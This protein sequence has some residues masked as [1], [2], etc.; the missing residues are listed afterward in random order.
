MQDLIH[1]KGPNVAEIAEELQ[2]KA[3]AFHVQKCEDNTVKTPTPSWLTD[4]RQNSSW[5]FLF[6][7]IDKFKIYMD[8]QETQ[9]SRNIVEK[10]Q[11]FRMRSFHFKTYYRDSNQD[12]S[13][14]LRGVQNNGI[15]LRF[16]KKARISRQFFFKKWPTQ[17]IGKRIVIS[18][19]DAGTGE[20]PLAKE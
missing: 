9:N 18:V 11:S 12:S 6:P 20:F 14:D 8:I 4:P 2:I 7:E 10:E 5:L 17:S 1:W 13:A 3:K 16:Q 15:S 19:Y